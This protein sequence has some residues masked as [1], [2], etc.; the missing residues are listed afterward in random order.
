VGGDKNSV[1]VADCCAGLHM[2]QPQ[3]LLQPAI[4]GVLPDP[5]NVDTGP[6]MVPSPA[7][8]I[9]NERTPMFILLLENFTYLSQSIT[10]NITL[11]FKKFLLNS[12]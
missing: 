10:D 2:L 8:T 12:Y 7:Q 3:L 11:I 1:Q 4:H 5:S 9:I 6:M